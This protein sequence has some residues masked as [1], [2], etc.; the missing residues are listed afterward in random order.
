MLWRLKNYISLHKRPLLTGLAAIIVVTGGYLGYR[1]TRPKAKPVVQKVAPKPPPPVKTTKPSPLTG[2]EL[3]IAL[4]DRPIQAVVIENHTDARPQ[5]GLTDAGAVY[6]VLSE[7]GITRFMALYLEGRPSI[8]GPVRSL[9]TQFE[10]YTLEYNAP[11]AH[12][13]GNADALDQVIPLGVISENYFWFSKYFYRAGDRFAPHNL[14]TS[15]DLLDQLKVAIQQ[16]RPATFTPYPRKNDGPIAVTRPTITINY[17][18]TAYQ[19]QYRYDQAT[20]MYTRWL[21]GAPHVDRN[22]NQQ[23]KT[24]NIVI[25]YVPVRYGVTRIGEQTAI[26]DTLGSGKLQVFRD[27]GMIEGTWNKSSHKSRTRLLDAAGKDIPLDR[28]VTW[29]N[30]VPP[31]RPAS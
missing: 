28:G 10:T 9:R 4:A 13:G 27:G 31:D 18:Y 6:E 22:N 26:M 16:S 7:G 2:V 30:I 3:P 5:S 11:I 14:Y 12:A 23:L 17:S 24:K 25:M 15:M 8:I 29:I 1:L 19:V 21:A 20:N